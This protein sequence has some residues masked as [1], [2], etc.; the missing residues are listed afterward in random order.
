[1]ASGPVG[2]AASQVVLRALELARLKTDNNNAARI[3]ITAMTV[4][5]SMIVN[6][7]FEFMV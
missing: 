6:P 1:L 3:P 7:R 5:N 4:S 2:A